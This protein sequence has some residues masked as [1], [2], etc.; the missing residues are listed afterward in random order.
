ME[1]AHPNH[2]LPMRT[3][4]VWKKINLSYPNYFAV[5]NHYLGRSQN[6]FNRACIFYNGAPAAQYIQSVKDSKCSYFISI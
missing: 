3:K 5:S 6:G 2:T 4:K 1:T